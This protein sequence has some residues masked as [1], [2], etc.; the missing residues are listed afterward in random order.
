MPLCA[1][2]LQAAKGLQPPSEEYEEKM[3]AMDE[4]VQEMKAGQGGQGAQM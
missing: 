1:L 2:G 4:A 3:R